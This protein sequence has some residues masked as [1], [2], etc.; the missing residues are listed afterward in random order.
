MKWSGPHTVAGTYPDGHMELSVVDGK[1]LVVNGKRLKNYH[2]LKHLASPEGI[3]D[4][5][6]LGK[7]S[8]HGTS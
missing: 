3:D 1:S 4:D 8:Q 2:I 6:L 5:L 7:G